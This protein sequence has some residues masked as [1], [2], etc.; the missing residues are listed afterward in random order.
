M[1]SS[2]RSVAIAVDW[3]VEMLHHGAVMNGVSWNKQKHWKSGG[4]RAVALNTVL[5]TVLAINAVKSEARRSILESLNSPSYAIH[6]LN[7]ICA[8]RRL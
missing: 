5:H 7:S 1:P 4:M 8:S 6:E 3:S 2:V